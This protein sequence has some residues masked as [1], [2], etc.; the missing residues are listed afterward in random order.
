MNSTKKMAVLSAVLV[1]GTELWHETG[2]MRQKEQ[3]LLLEKELLEVG[4]VIAIG[5]K[6]EL[7]RRR[8]KESL[9]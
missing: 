5:Q 1:E 7:R 9:R 4:C 2:W 3:V 8:G 6:K